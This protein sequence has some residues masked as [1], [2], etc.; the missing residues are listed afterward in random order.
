MLVDTGVDGSFFLRGVQQFLQ[1]LNQI[2][3]ASLYFVVHLAQL[4]VLLQK[5]R[6]RVGQFL[7]FFRIAFLFMRRDFFRMVP[8]VVLVRSNVLSVFFK[9]GFV[10]QN[11][12]LQL[13]QHR[14]GSEVFRTPTT[15]FGFPRVMLGVRRG[16]L[17]L[18]LGVLLFRGVVRLS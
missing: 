3:V 12:S 9:D 17:F 7:V 18:H 15:V 10:F 4:G 2:V 11:A 8:H 16:M 14:Q 1:L 13:G 6:V 5:L